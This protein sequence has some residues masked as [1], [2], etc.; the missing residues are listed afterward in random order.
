M[1][2]GPRWRPL[3]ENSASKACIDTIGKARLHRGRRRNQQHDTENYPAA[4]ATRWAREPEIAKMKEF[5]S[6][7]GI[8]PK[9]V[10][11][12][13]LTKRINRSSPN[14]QGCSR[15]LLRT[16]SEPTLPAR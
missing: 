2:R 1:G 11:I 15:A 7:D 16:S 6:P 10:A 3:A 14:F 13:A 4:S 12:A 5:Y 8:R 9:G